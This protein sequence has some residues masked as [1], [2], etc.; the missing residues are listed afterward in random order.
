MFASNR[1]H[2]PLPQKFSGSSLQAWYFKLRLLVSSRHSLTLRK[3]VCFGKIAQLS[4]LFKSKVVTFMKNY[5]DSLIFSR[6]LF[7]DIFNHD[8]LAVLY[9]FPGLMCCN[10]L[11]CH[12]FLDFCTS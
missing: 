2:H 11:I 8:E 6:V 7:Y 3:L 1:Q 10:L 5:K 9:F 4:E 12:F